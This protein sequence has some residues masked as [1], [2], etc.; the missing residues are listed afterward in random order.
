MEKKPNSDLFWRKIDDHAAI[1]IPHILFSAEKHAFEN[2]LDDLNCFWIS[3]K[4]GKGDKAGIVV[5]VSVAIV[6]MG[7][8]THERKNV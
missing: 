1:G 4:E 6:G 8:E 3:C 2:D 7:H 5:V